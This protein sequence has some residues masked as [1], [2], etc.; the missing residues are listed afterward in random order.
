[1]MNRAVHIEAYAIVSEDGMLTDAAGNIPPSLKLDADQRFFETGLD[2]VDIVV[3]GRNSQEQLSHS[4]TRRRLIAT[5][6][7]PSIAPDPS[8]GRAILWNP[9]GA[10]FDEALA[11]F[12]APSLKVAVIGG[13]RVFELFLDLYDVFYLSRVA[14][15]RLPG[16]LPIFGDVPLRTPEAVLA[17]HG[18]DRPRHELV[19]PGKGLTI[20][21]WRRSE[22]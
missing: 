9:A 13:P 14:N 21:G 16:G 4:A 10:S 18:L 3:H 11:A 5:H 19:G 1:M 12:A 22:I 17:A 8:N 6:S 7:I 15:V 20:T 2:A